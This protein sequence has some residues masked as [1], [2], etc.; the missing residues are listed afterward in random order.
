MPFE[1]DAENNAVILAKA[2][3][4]KSSDSNVRAFALLDPLVRFELARWLKPSGPLEWRDLS[5]CNFDLAAYTQRP[6]VAAV[7]CK[8]SPSKRKLSPVEA[9]TLR[10][11]VELFDALKAYCDKLGHRAPSAQSRTFWA[12]Y[13][14][15]ARMR[16]DKDP[17]A[18]LKNPV[19]RACVGE[20]SNEDIEMRLELSTWDFSTRLYRKYGF[21]HFIRLHVPES[22]VRK[23][24]KSPKFREKF[25]E[26]LEMDFVGAFFSSDTTLTSRTRWWPVRRTNTCMRCSTAR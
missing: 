21:G 24:Q 6:V 5:R 4:P 10:N 22:F 7:P 14:V 18:S 9:E 1:L 23:T 2:P 17:I 8:G 25:R 20:A 12:T 19:L 13:L 11:P 15:W 3:S 26:F 16:D